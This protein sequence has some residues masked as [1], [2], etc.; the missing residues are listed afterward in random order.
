MKMSLSGKL[1]LGFLVVALI[2]LFVGTV[3]WYGLQDSASQI[4]ILG[5]ESI[6]KITDLETIKAAKA[7]I[8]VELRTLTSPYITSTTAARS[9][10]A[11]KEAQAD[12]TAAETDYDATEITSEE[13]ALSKAFRDAE[14]V[15]N[16]DDDAYFALFQKLRAA[17]TKPE[18]I[19]QQLTTAAE[20]GQTQAE[21]DKMLQSLQAHLDFVK[22]YY[23]KTVVAQ[24]VSTSAFLNIL[25][26]SFSGIGVVLALLLGFFLARSISRPIIKVTGELR[27]ASKALES[28]SFQ[29]SSSSQELSSGSS[30]LASSI[31]EMTSSLEELQSIIES[32]TKNVNQSEHLMQETSAE[33]QKVTER[34]GELKNQLSDIAG[35]SKKISKIIKV[36]DDIAFQ[37][38][39]LALN[40]AVEAARAGDAGKG[41]AVVADQVKSLAQKSA[42]AAK[43]TA[44]LI[45]IAIESVAKGESLGSVVVEA[46]EVAVDKATKVAVLLDEV[47]RASKEQLKGA[48]Q[49]N[50]A[51]SQI[52]SVVQA[53]AASSEE[54]ASAGEELFSQAESLGGNVN[55]LNRIVTGHLE[56]I[57]QTAVHPDKERKPAAKPGAPH[58]PQIAHDIVKRPRQDSP[59][60]ED[61]I[62]LNDFKDY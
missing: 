5:D 57:T 42:E 19:A 50:Q 24:A 26:L 41:F 28:A 55:E 40:A 47:N 38:N 15:S 7:Q 61:V 53:T 17:K 11:V 29:V 16:E 30:E 8:K 43:E 31:E 20:D 49:I 39:I 35:N 60:P 36:I 33:S 48:N 37:T 12:I 6:P 25:M 54:N 34:M 32:N 10:K 45:E 22:K 56:A 59:R 4:K 23:G 46:Q 51:V 1:I 21:F 58:L 18:D 2:T 52:N 62:P 27:D 3:G 13:A 9:L 14:K 44:D